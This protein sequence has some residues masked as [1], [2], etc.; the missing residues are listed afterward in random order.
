[1]EIG[2]RKNVLGEPSTRTSTNCP[3]TISG[4]G[5][6]SVSLISTYRSWILSTDFTVK[7]N[8]YFF[9]IGAKVRLSEQNAKGKNVFLWILE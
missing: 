6:P 2:R 7:S 5:F 9:I 4:N 8:K 3:G 1:M